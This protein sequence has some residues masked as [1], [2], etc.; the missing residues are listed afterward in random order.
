[1]KDWL[2]KR[3]VLPKLLIPLF[4]VLAM[5]LVVFYA[6]NEQRIVRQGGDGPLY[7]N[8]MDSPALIRRGF[9]PS[10]IK[11]IPLITDLDETGEWVR[12]RE[13]PLRISNSLLPDL[14][15]RTFLSPRGNKAEEFTI[16]IPVDLDQAAMDFLN[17][18]PSELPGI[19]LGY[20]GENW[21]IFFNGIPVRSEIHIENLIRGKVTKPTWVFF[22]FCLYLTL[23]QMFFCAQYGEEAIQL[24][25]VAVITYFAYVLFYNIIYYYLFAKKRGRTDS[26]VSQTLIINIIT[27]ALTIFLCGV[28]EI[29]DILFFH[30]SYSL[31]P[32]SNFVVHIGM[33]FALAG[34]F[35]GMYQRLERSNIILENTVKER[36]RELE[37]QT[38]IAVK[39]SL[40]KS[41][42]LATM[43]HEIKTPL[44]VVSVHVQQAK[45]LFE[46]GGDDGETSFAGETSVAET[47]RH[48]L[49][50]AQEETMRTARITDNTLRLA[51]M[52][53]GAPKGGQEA[54]QEL[55]LLDMAALL[56]TSAEA[57]R[58]LLEKRGNRLV[59]DI[60]DRLPP[61]SG[62]ADALIQVMVN[63][64]SNANTHTQNGEIV[65]AAEAERKHIRVTVTDSGSGISPE[66]L[67]VVFDRQIS[68]GGS[69]GIGLAICKEIIASHNGKIK[70]VSE[71][72]KGTTVA[73]RV[74]MGR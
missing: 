28:Y 14:P 22:F 26:E 12:F 2:K 38:A 8:L 53:E 7:R 51:S 42:F 47:I 74:P 55:K 44:T 68:G 52:Q 60:Q 65:V 16:A 27:G 11:E 23:T 48:S 69:T 34:R 72:G 18:N 40:Y 62:S 73:F 13:T 20:I 43:S 6:W 21:E 17:D 41:E 71:V 58:I 45:E 32:Y 39:A 36:T 33:N 4:Y 30:Y 37:K 31:F 24:W 56:T 49:T 15:G 35:S 50:R 63:L 29:L 1:M 64:L 61:V 70:I 5:T 25:D 67:P 10:Q 59:V 57:Y 19:F 3:K 66:L 9:E 54:R 46:A